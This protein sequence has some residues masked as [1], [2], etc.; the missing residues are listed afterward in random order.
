MMMNTIFQTEVGEGWV[1]VY[2]DDLAIYTTKL[3]H[4]TEEG[5]Q[6]HHQTYVHRILDKL[7]EHD[8]YLKPEKCEF[9]KDEIEYLGVI[10]GKG[11]LQMHPSFRE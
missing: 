6:H 11:C 2:M 3:P 8:L 7:R 9:E 4:K 5:H 1:S 10:V